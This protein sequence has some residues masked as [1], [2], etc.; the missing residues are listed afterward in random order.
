MTATT[1]FLAPGEMTLC[2]VALEMI[3]CME[4]PAL[5]ASAE[6]ASGSGLIVNP[7]GN[8]SVTT[9]LDITNQ[10]SLTSNPDIANSTIVPHVTVSMTTPVTG[11]V[12][13]A[14]FALTVNPNSTITVDV[15]HTTNIDSFIL[16]YGSDGRGL[17]FND[18]STVDPGSS[19]LYTFH[20]LPYSLD[21]ALSLNAVAGGTYYLQ[22]ADSSNLS[23]LPNNASFDVNISVSNP[24]ALGTD[25]VAGNDFLSGGSGDDNLFGGAGDDIL[26]G[27]PGNDVL[28]GGLGN[29]LLVGGGGNN[30]FEFDAQIGNDTI[31]DFSANKDVVQFNHA[32]FTNYA[33]VM[34]SAHREGHDTVITHDASNTVTLENVAIS[35]LH[36]SNFQ[37]TT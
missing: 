31:A 15:D 18:D 35:S 16:L 3:P 25:G 23:L 34:G 17:T 21:S 9:A 19:F 28:N 10:F 20:H 27:G 11:T 37:F 26:D 1:K 2:S 13:D 5:K 7:T 33:A 8:T 6:W 29:D 30:T 4:T 22:L 36:P 12:P 14:W 32:L 24:P